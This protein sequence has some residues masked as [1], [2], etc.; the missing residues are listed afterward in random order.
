[1]ENERFVLF[2]GY[3]FQK[4]WRGLLQSEKHE[5][6]TQHYLP[7]RP[8]ALSESKPGKLQEKLNQGHGMASRFT[9][10]N[11]F[12]GC[13]SPSSSVGSEPP[14]PT[15]CSAPVAEN[16]H[17]RT[18]ASDVR[19]VYRLPRHVTPL[20]KQNTFFKDCVNLDTSP[21]KVKKLT[22]KSP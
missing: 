9:S 8:L 11:G 17:V 16:E 2:K 4:R 19:P 14:S 10:T 12:P 21:H 20:V 22:K 1:M 18:P 3:P 13:Y 6:F 15:T 5:C 7:S